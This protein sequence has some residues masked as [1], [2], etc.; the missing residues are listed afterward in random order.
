MCP[1]VSDL[2]IPTLNLP[3]L[4]QEIWDHGNIKIAFKHMN[5]EIGTEAVLFP[6]NEHIN[7][8]FVAVQTKT[9]FIGKQK[10]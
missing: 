9:R 6:E 7:V 1:P 2:F 8:I 4:L 3:I 5:V 10:L